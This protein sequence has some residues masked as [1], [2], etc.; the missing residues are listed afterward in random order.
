MLRCP[1]QSLTHRHTQKVCFLLLEYGDSGAKQGL[2]IMRFCQTG[3]DV[4]LVSQTGEGDRETGAASEGTFGSQTEPGA[5][6]KFCV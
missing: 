3:G 2:R 5:W 4:M 6:L 1:A